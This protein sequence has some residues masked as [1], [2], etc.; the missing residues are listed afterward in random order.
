MNESK[1]TECEIHC[2]IKRLN[3]RRS[4]Q[5]SLYFTDF[6]PVLDISHQRWANVST[7]GPQQVLKID[8]GGSGAAADGLRLLLE[9]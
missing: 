5:Q 9:P 3:L 8:R 1:F 4:Q 7:A 2:N 6:I